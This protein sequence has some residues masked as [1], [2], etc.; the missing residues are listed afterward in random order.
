MKNKIILIF[1]LLSSFAFTQVHQ[2]TI[3]NNESILWQK[4]NLQDRIDMKV[5]SALETILNKNDFIVD[6]DVRINEENKPTPSGAGGSKTNKVR[7]SDISDAKAKDDY[8][9]FSK[10][11]I[12]APYVDEALDDKKQNQKAQENLKK[13]M[14]SFDLFNKLESIVI[15]VI[16][17]EKAHKGTKENVTNL[18]KRL[19]FNLKGIEPEFNIEY[20]PLRKTDISSWSF[21]SWLRD[22][23]HGIALVLSMLTLGI[24]L[25]L[26][27]KKLSQILGGSAAEDSNTQI[28]ISMKSD[29]DEDKSALNPFGSSES[30]DTEKAHLIGIERLISFMEQSPKDALILI[31]EWI[32]SDKNEAKK[33]LKAIV[34]QFDTDRLMSIFKLLSDD[35]KTNWK[36]KLDSVPTLDEVKIA[37]KFINKQVVENIMSPKAIDDPEIVQMI[38]SASA[39]QCARFINDNLDLSSVLTSTM[40]SAHLAK[41][42]THLDKDI[43][44]KT[45]EE[46]ISFKDE[47]LKNLLPKFKEVFPKYLEEVQVSPFLQKMLDLIPTAKTAQEQMLYTLYLKQG[48]KEQALKVAKENF[49]SFLI[50]ELEDKTLKA[51]IQSFPIEKRFSLLFGLEL[52]LKEAFTKAFAPQGTKAFEMMQL[53]FEK[54]E[55]DEELKEKVLLAKEN[56]WFNFVEHTRN[57]FY[58][59]KSYQSQINSMLKTWFKE[60]TQQDKTHVA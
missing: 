43:Y 30:S 48:P 10:L 29:E 33:A 21:F 26:A 11:G 28:D 4:I 35:E 32:A 60:D 24:F 53:E 7:L 54:I 52:S 56:L 57:F 9:L 2:F 38:T 16:I 37:N 40:N 34:H 6:V 20:A 58:K 3:N 49:P 31:K 42:F 59:D 39:K 12:I 18:I 8:V 47:Q 55:S 17:D 5:S 25:W 23:R 51:I 27:A 50:Q 14:E 44:E 41:I 15:K 1:I 19:N 13:L 46:G 45:I 36:E 22:N